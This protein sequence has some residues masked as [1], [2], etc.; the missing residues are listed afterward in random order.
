MRGISSLNFRKHRI[1][2]TILAVILIAIV[3]GAGF[4][5]QRDNQKELSSASL[6]VGSYWSG[7]GI[8]HRA[9]NGTGNYVGSS[10]IDLKYSNKFTVTQR[11]TNIAMMMVEYSETW[12]RTA[13]G[14]WINQ[15]RNATNGSVSG[16]LAYYTIDFTTMK[17]VGV[18][19]NQ[20][21]SLGHLTYFFID[22]Q[23]VRQGGN[24][25]VD[26]DGSTVPYRVGAFRNVSI[27]EVGV[28]VW[29]LTHVR[30]WT[31]YWRV[32]GKV[33]TGSE[34]RVNLYDKIYCAIVGW[35]IV[36]NYAYVG[37]EGNWTEDYFEHFRVTDSN[38]LTKTGPAAF[39]MQ[40]SLLAIS[41]VIIVLVVFACLL[42]IRRGMFAKVISRL[43]KRLGADSNSG[44]NSPVE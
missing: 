42:V 41:V 16:I 40:P 33:S 7:N 34:T 26:W 17:I 11:E 14:T 2:L 10:T 35:E 29:P 13:S 19:I 38:F 27:N 28:A 24:V 39:L 32:G 36:G 1:K 5:L 8:V 37:R 23:T 31:G 18:S 30:D 44:V 12:S 43:G 9:L 6:P 4:Y 3:V 20:K 25:L 15:N 22:P 21:Q